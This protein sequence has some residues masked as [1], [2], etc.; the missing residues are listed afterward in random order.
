MLPAERY[1]ASTN[2][3][4]RLNLLNMRYDPIK[5]VEIYAR[6]QEGLAALEPDPER[7]LKYADFIEAYANLSED[8]WVCYCEE[9]L[10]NSEQQ[11]IIT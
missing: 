1:I 11:E 6:A 3:V 7:R 4:A 10:P 2:I 9:F 5:R 8:E